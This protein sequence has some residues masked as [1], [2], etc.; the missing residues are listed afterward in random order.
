MNERINFYT[1]LKNSQPLAFLASFSIIIGILSLDKPALP[2][3]HQ[4][5]ILAGFMFIFSFIASLVSQISENRDKALEI[6]GRGSTYFFLSV[7][8]LYLL[9]IA[10]KFSTIF[11]QIPTFVFGWMLL[12][13]GGAFFIQIVIKLQ[14]TKKILR[15]PNKLLDIQNE[16]AQPIIGSG[17]LILG[18]FLLASAFLERDF[19]WIVLIQTSITIGGIGALVLF[20]S[21]I[22]E[23]INYL[24]KGRKK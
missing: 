6:L 2:A 14:T 7:G 24:R 8:I 3:I 20:G 1:A 17:F 23:G 11:S 22:I 21:A 13:M 15:G 4:D 19:D 9:S 12:F 10:A 16:I 5:A 18:G